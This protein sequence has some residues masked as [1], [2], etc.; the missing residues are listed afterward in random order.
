MFSAPAI[1]VRCDWSNTIF[2]N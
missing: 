1:I 2:L